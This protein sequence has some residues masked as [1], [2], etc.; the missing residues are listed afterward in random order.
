MNTSDAP[1]VKRRNVAAIGPRLRLL[2]LFVLALVAMLVANSVYLVSITLMEWFSGGHYQNYFY[3]LMFL[4]HI[5]LG[6][7]FLTPFVIFSTIH[8]LNTK[9]RKKRR[10]VYVGY[11]LLSVSVVLLVSG[12]MLVRI[13]GLFELKTPS[14]RR[15]IYWL[16]VIT[17]LVVLWLYWLHRQVGPKIKWRQGRNYLAFVAVMM[18]LMLALHSQDPRQWN[19]VG[20]QSGA[21]Y[22]EP[23][24]V[25]TTT[26]KFI[27]ARALMM[28]D[29][30]RNC[31]ADVH[32]SW[33]DSVHHLSSFNNPV[34]LASI[35]ET[36]DVLLKRDGSI[37]ASRLCAGCHDPVPFLSGAFDDPNFD[38][39]KHPT[40]HAGVTCTT[41]HAITHVNSVKGNGDYTIEEP[42]HYPFAYSDNPVLRWINHQLV[43][44]KPAMHNKTFLKPLHKTTE[45]CSVCHKVNLPGELTHYKQFLRAQDH[46]DSFLLSG[47]SGH[48]A[49]SFYYPKQ[50]EKNCN[51]CHLPLM[52]SDDFGTDFFDDSGILKAHNHLFP[53]ANTALAW[54]RDKPEV[55]DAHRQFLKN[56]VM[57]VDIFGIKKGKTIDAPLQAPLRPL[58]PKLE[59]GETYVV[60]TVLRALREMG[61]HFTQGTT[62]SNQIWLDV[63]IT[64]GGKVI[65]RSGALD[66]NR[67][68]DPWAH[69]VN[70]F[71]LDRNG[72]RI[73]RRNPQDI[74]TP[75][76]NHQIG[77]GTAQTVHYQF[78]L[79][80]DIDAP[81]E[82]SV[83]LQYRKFDSTLMDFVHKS[84]KPG[85]PL[86]RG[87]QP[88]EP[89]LNQLPII[90]IAED[91]VVLPVAGVDVEPEQ[92]SSDVAV[93]ERW[94]D[95]GMGLLQKGKA[96]L[97]Q[98]ADAFTK[99]EQAGRY[100][101]PL[102]L[103]RVYFREGRLDE[104]VEAINRATAFDSP[105][106]PPWTIAWLSGMINRQQGN[107][108]AAERNYRSALYDHTSEMQ[109][110]G[111]DFSLDYVVVN[112]YGEVLFDLARQQRGESRAE[113]R[114]KYLEQSI[115]Q[116]SKTLEIDPENVTAHYNLQLLYAQLGKAELSRK[117]QKLHALY[118]PDDNA[119]DIAIA[120]A[121]KR[122]P[123]ANH[124]AEAVVIYPLQRKGAPDLP[125]TALISKSR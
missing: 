47:I 33:K 123:A 9:N 102:N 50:A 49:R 66:E 59:P 5:L 95:Y 90:T 72:Y 45:F 40:A 97:R 115:E 17:P 56:N 19:V 32:A 7:L 22:F 89:Y 68:V 112:Q 20:P 44:A 71:L 21:K 87:A 30:C 125:E 51:D 12:I 119:T 108:Q 54:L 48:S 117:H 37:Q 98:A 63:T 77:P 34:Y 94:N 104:A 83:K 122:Y 16:H 84:R 80:K 100:D 91:R 88:G 65:G 114:Q 61:H 18:L 26:G 70:V 116:F 103:A 1:P 75:L 60:E 52:E 76:Y 11:A 58:L 62:D 106:P 35:R 81:V 55:I 42:L 73:E 41:C 78:E 38:D 53:S 74:F 101:G 110:R 85:D 36:R 124:A 86:L 4:C 31:H 107:L 23:S 29:Y 82:I 6:L 43:K 92:Q 96:T 67:R 69:F 120:A 27:P 79:P 14:L 93:W 64:S 99:V 28:D 10:T 25:R 111:F 39:V 3:L 13:S 121:R 118:K 109:K 15:F 113:Q 8:F 46:Y 105:G 24:P 57:R 2:Y